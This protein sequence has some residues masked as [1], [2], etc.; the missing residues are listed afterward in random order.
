M[1][2]ITRAI[3]KAYDAGAHRATVQLAGSLAVWLESVAVSDALEPP[4]LVAGRECGVLFFT[5]DN[6]DDACII[7]VYNAVPLGTNRLRDA[8]GDTRVEVERTADEDKLAVTIAGTLRYLVQGASPH[9]QWT[10]DGHLSG[11][12]GVGVAPSATAQVRSQ[13]TYSGSVGLD[14]LSALVVGASGV[15]GPLRGVAGEVQIQSGAGTLAYA[16]GLEFKVSHAGANTV[17]D[18][19]GAQVVIDGTGPSTNRIAFYG[20]VDALDTGATLRAGFVSRV[21]PSVASTTYPDWRSFFSRGAI[22]RST[23]TA[24]YHYA[25]ENLTTFFGGAATTVYGYYSPN[26]T[27]GTNRLPFY[28]GGIAANKNDASGNRFR[29][30]TQFGSTAGSFGTGD[31][32]IGIANAP[33]APSTNPAGGG[34]LYAA[35]GALTWR[36]SAG[37]VTV[38]APA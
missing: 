18:L 15:T 19:Y 13:G 6:P 29:S 31:G 20:Q 17:T 24:F 7:S 3:I 33:T 37:T 23:I 1:A 21:G 26:L 30:N 9:H 12:L 34:V 8:D 35:A 5:E 14:A 22:S 32:V 28:D 11:V 36:G 27:V 2:T 16:R 10:G 4:E 25:V 38:I